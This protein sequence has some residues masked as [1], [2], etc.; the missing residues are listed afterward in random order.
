MARRLAVETAEALDVIE[1]DRGLAER[2]VFGVYRLRAGQVQHRPQQ[3]GGVAVREHEAVAIRPD[4]IAGIESEDAVPERV[5]ERRERHRCA[6]MAGVGRLHRIHRQGADGVDRKLVER[7]G[8]R[9]GSRFLGRW[10]W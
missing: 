1:R 10:L 3:H 8:I 5:H 7:R 6:G 4:R 9:H 2:L